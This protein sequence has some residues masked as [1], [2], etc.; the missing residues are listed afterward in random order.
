MKI[1]DDMTF[2]GRPEALERLITRLDQSPQIGPWKRDPEA[3][4]S[5]AGYGPEPDTYR[6]FRTRDRTE[7]SDALLWLFAG[8]KGASWR[9]TN[10]VPAVPDAAFSE[11]TYYSLLMSFREATL[12]LA[13]ETGVTISVP[14]LDVGPEYWLTPDQESLLQ[15]FSRNANR[16]TGSAHPQDRK[17][18]NEFV[19]AVHRDGSN[20]GGAD[21]QRILIEHEHWP[22][23]MAHELAIDF[24]KQLALLR[25]FAKSA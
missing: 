22:E 12:P 8:E 2:S 10:I 4:Q 19:I 1:F 15:L 11:A 24:D 21:V 20:V 23:G 5:Y 6:C 25:D 3:E 7:F 18:W 9:V 17:R 14:R 16:S 13:N